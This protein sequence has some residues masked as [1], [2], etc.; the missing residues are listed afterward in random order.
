MWESAIDE[1]FAYLDSK[2]TWK[3]DDTPGAQRHPSHV[4]LKVKLK[5][6]G[7]VEGFRARV[8]AGGNFQTYGEDYKETYAPVVSFS[9]VRIFHYLVL[10]M[11]M[12][13]AQLDLKT[14]FL[15]GDLAEDVWVMSPRGILEMKSRCHKLAKAM[16][17]LK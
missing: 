10:C 2:N 14:A 16:Y 9:P 5:S 6:D 13:V 8:V 1:E 15:N 17:G 7:D 4:V 11:N 12:C 3:V